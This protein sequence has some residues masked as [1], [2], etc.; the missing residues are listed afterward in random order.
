MKPSP[1]IGDRT[2]M[3]S[4]SPLAAASGLPLKDII[5]WD[6]PNWSV[7]LSYWQPWLDCTTGAKQRVLVL[8]ERN[9][10]ISLWFALLGFR[11][12]C[13]DLGVPNEPVLRM[14]HRWGV[15]DR[16]EYAAVDVFDIQ[17][18]D[19][20]F[21]IVACKSVIGGLS[22]VYSDRSTRTIPHQRLAVNE[23]HRI[24]KPGGVF[25]G[26]ENLR[27]TVLHMLMRRV[28]HG[29]KLGWR[30]LRGAEVRWLFED[31]ARCEQQAYGFLGTHWG[32]LFGLNTMCA[33][34]DR[35]VSPALPF[36][37]HYISFIR[38]RKAGVLTHGGAEPAS[39]AQSESSTVIGKSRVPS[40]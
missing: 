7:A 26:A 21:D 9:G 24:L 17:F 4:E 14:H 40:R 11:V 19:A 37:W 30:Y 12:L 20:S 13:S 28:R 39:T 32:N 22:S 3:Q 35:F 2:S 29:R 6:V 31:F 5:G 33:R 1:S 8:G 10:G 18:P 34:F 36:E 27:G 15:G 16:I 38:A 25:C 23:I